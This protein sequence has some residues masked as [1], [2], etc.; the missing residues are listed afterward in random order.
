MF[1]TI[2]N[3][4]TAD[5]L[6]ELR[7]IAARAN[8]IDG[9]ISAPGAPVKNN[10]VVGDRALFDRSAQL[11]ADALY[12]NEDFRVFAFPKAMVPPVLTRYGEGMYYGTHTDAAF[13][14]HPTRMLRSDLSCTVFLSDP[15]SYE[16][17]DLV[18]RIGN[19]E[20]RL[21][22]P[23]GAA[24]VY[25]STTLHRVDKVTRGERLVA[26]TFIESRIADME[27]RELLYELSEVAAIAGE[28]MDIDTYTRLQRVQ[29]NLLRKWSDPD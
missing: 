14:A 15:D 10:L 12:R 23:A 29:Q 28:K 16:G 11:V 8:F 5:E 21:R 17:G 20:L 7:A 6:A 2:E 18:S 24:I 26:L 13:M 22:A 25:P 27:E 19:A 9:R 4:L 1:N 3:I